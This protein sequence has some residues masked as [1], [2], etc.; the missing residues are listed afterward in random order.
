LRRQWG[1]IWINIDNIDRKHEANQYVKEQ[2]ADR[3]SHYDHY[4]DSVPYLP[5]VTNYIYIILYICI[6]YCFSL[7]SPTGDVPRRGRDET[8]RVDTL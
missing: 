6:L 1:E 5:V 7:P 4:F 2:L 3:L 8:R